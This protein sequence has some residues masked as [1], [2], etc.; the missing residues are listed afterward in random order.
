[1]AVVVMLDD[2]RWPISGS[3]ASTGQAIEPKA[4]DGDCH[5]VFHLTC[6]IDFFDCLGVFP[7]KTHAH[8]RRSPRTVVSILFRD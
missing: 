8:A 7:G 5:K 3:D 4:H 1:M 2:L 6:S